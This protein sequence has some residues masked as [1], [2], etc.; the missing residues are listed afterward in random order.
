MDKG[1]ERIQK[2]NAFWETKMEEQLRTFYMDLSK[3]LHNLRFLLAES[4]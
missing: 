3:I 2:D 4:F 1:C